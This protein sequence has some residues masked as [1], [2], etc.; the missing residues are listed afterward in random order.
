MGQVGL[1]GCREGRQ[2]KREARRAIVSLHLLPGFPKEILA[3]IGKGVGCG[4]GQD[5]F[6]LLS[7]F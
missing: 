2:E 6:A 4:E 1:K 3:L 7:A 5:E